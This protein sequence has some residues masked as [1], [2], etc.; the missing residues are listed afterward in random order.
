LET[1]DHANVTPTES[2]ASVGE[3]AKSSF[4]DAFTNCTWLK[5]TASRLRSPVNAELKDPPAYTQGR[6]GPTTAMTS[7]DIDK[8][9]SLIVTLAR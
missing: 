1:T 8:H 6:L 7:V 9:P 2:A 5:T 4:P 3:F